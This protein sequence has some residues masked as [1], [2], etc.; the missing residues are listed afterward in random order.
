MRIVSGKLKG[1]KLALFKG[2]SIRPT[3]D[4][5]REAIFDILTV[6]W[7]GREVLDLFAGT[8]GLGIEALSRGARRV[9][10]VENYPQA[11]LLLEKNI[12]ALNLIGSCEVIKLRVEEGISLIKRKVWKFD[13]AF[14][15]PPY[16]KGLADSSLRLIAGSDILKKDGLVV[17][18]HHYKEILSDSYRK[19]RM[20]DQRGYGSTGISFYT[21]N[22]KP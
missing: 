6:E 12:N 22:Y 15:D 3:S 13:V 20:S 8:G 17:V 11:L 18:E 9:V 4:I 2:R 19:L 1:R 14:L 10:F 21:H 16:G 7:E 5:V